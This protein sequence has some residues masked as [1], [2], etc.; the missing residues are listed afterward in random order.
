[1]TDLRTLLD[2]AAPAPVPVSRSVVEADLALGRRA[3][4]RR[5]A[6]RGTRSGVLLVA[7]S[8]TLVLALQGGL[9]AGTVPGGEPRPSLSHDVGATALVAYTGPQP[10][11]FTIDKVPAGWVVEGVDQGALTLVPAGT[12]DFDAYRRL[13]ADGVRAI[14][15]SRIAVSRSD[16]LPQGVPQGTST[17]VQVDGT[18][19]LVVA[20]RDGEGGRLAGRS[21]FLPQ[22]AG[23][24]LTVQTP[25]GLG[26]SVQQLVEF[27]AGV[28][29]TGQ[30]L[31]TVG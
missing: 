1:M 16:H 22:T 4:R 6:L 26:W 11:G 9:P 12:E 5:R 25:A 3:L 28:H 13:A 27:S 10:A 7:A 8:A 24:Y 23:G 15:G 29:V 2:L 31:T 17:E 30:A 19:A 14:G 20:W 18:E 21:L